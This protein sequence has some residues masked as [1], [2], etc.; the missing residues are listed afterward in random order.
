MY[1][2]CLEG[3]APAELE[4][5]PQPRPDSSPTVAGLALPLKLSDGGGHHRMDRGVDQG[6]DLPLTRDRYSDDN[7]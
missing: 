5:L 6:W 1:L 7:P 3:L 4:Q 2:V